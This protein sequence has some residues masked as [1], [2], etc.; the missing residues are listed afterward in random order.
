MDKKVWMS[1]DRISSREDNRK[2]D[3]K[4]FLTYAAG[5]ILGYII[6][7]SSII[8]FY[9]DDPEHMD[10]IDRQE[11]N[12]KYLANLNKDRVSNASRI[13]DTTTKDI[14]YTLGSPDITEAKEVDGIT[15]Q[16]MFYRTHQVNNDNIT[17]KDEC[18]G[19]LFINER[20]IGWGKKTYSHYKKY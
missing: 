13:T 19:L 10:I 18:T 4:K 3:M 20:L 14:I 5:S 11:F 2:P 15:Y 16:I 17:T 9:N 12:L 8:N 1:R 6:L 7:A